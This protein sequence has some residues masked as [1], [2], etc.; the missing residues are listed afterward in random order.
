MRTLLTGFGPFGEVVNNPSAR[1][2]A[3]FEQVGAPGH[4]LTTRLLPVSYARAEREIRGLLTTGRFDGAVLLGVAARE[5]QLRLEQLG[6][7]QPG[8]RP[9]SDGDTA[10]SAERHP[11]APDRYRATV[12]LEPLVEVLASDGLP[13][14][15]SD[16]AGSYVCNHTYYTALHAIAAHGLPT[17]CFFLHLPADAETFAGP[18]DGPTMPLE[19]QIQAVERV[20]GWLG[21]VQP[22]GAPDNTGG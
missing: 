4:E 8:K 18:H 16:D 17:R 11:G 9:D 21:R 7:W 15:L 20:L 10:A 22:V 19:Q 12:E 2:V 5:P 1:I 14:R 3:H 6:C 13:A